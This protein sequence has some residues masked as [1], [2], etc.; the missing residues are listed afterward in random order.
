MSKS[1]VGMSFSDILAW[2]K[3]QG[4]TDDELNEGASQ[5]CL[6]IQGGVRDST[7]ECPT[8][9]RC[10]NYTAK[11]WCDIACVS[12]ISSWA[13][14]KAKKPLFEIEQYGH[15]IRNAH[16][17]HMV[18]KVD[19]AP[20][21]DR[22]PGWRYLCIQA[23]YPTPSKSTTDPEKVTCK[24][25]IRELKKEPGYYNRKYGGI[26]LVSQ[27][28]LKSVDDVE[29]AY[30][31]V[32]SKDDLSATGKITHIQNFPGLTQSEVQ[33]KM[34]EHARK[35]N[36]ALTSV[37]EKDRDPKLRIQSVDRVYHETWE[38]KLTAMIRFFM[39]EWGI[40]GMIALFILVTPAFVYY[41]IEDFIW[42]LKHP[43][44]PESAMTDWGNK[45]ETITDFTGEPTS[46]P[47]TPRPK[48]GEEGK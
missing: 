45:M 28:A 34:K 46:H 38:M 25:C 17:I 7:L 29:P 37:D 27:E 19:P 32:V 22:D 13:D 1:F 40:A 3:E 47:E 36:E 44:V 23:C 41:L 42:R 10:A 11:D 33:E 15:S 30:V 5:V 2:S 14:E 16:I 6:G 31:A 39:D 24:N 43:S 35:I 48:K 18:K 12:A 4:M 21:N 26:N 9:R 20:Y 8:L